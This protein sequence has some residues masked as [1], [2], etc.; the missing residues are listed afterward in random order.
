M[1]NI[2]AQNKAGITRYL[3]PDTIRRLAR[4]DLQAKC[5][6]EGFLSGRHRSQYFGFSTEFSE[7]RKYTPGDEIR[8]LDWTIFAR[9]NRLYTKKFEAQTSVECTLMVDIS[10]SMGYASHP[11]AGSK[12]EYATLLAA[13]ISYLLIHQQDAVGLAT[14]DQKITAYIK[15]SAKTS[16]LTDI[17]RLLAAA[18]TEN[19]S[20]FDDAF[21]NL[22]ALVHHRGLVIIF[23]D[24]LGD[25][26]HIRDSL[27]RLRYKGHD[28]IV[29][30]ILDPAELDLPFDGA[31]AFE[32]TEDPG[33]RIQTDPAQIRRAYQQEIKTFLH[34]IEKEC[35]NNQVEYLAL[36]TAQHFDI[37]LQQFLLRR[38]K[39]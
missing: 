37:A 25:R 24:F 13:A 19:A 5:I 21:S 31:I 35:L 8:H 1:K 27:R 36:S 23:S 4:L 28:V 34:E 20:N 15:P 29:F 22:T 26:R 39:M 9:T 6:A 32:D 10:A 7:H 2:G 11:D 38:R 33:Q 16:R 17:I 14:F 18:K 3:N 30:H 12:L